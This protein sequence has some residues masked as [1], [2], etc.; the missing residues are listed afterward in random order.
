MSYSRRINSDY[1]YEVNLPDFGWTH[2]DFDPALKDFRD[3]IRVMCY[4]DSRSRIQAHS[5][6][7]MGGPPIGDIIRRYFCS[8]D[9][10]IKK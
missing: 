3:E 5:I 9:Q 1:I 10:Q 2:M 8:K 7:V 6:R 4:M